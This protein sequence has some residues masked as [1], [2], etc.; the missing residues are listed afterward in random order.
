MTSTRCSPPYA[1]QG[2]TLSTISFY[3]CQEGRLARSNVRKKVN[4]ECH[5][6]GCFLLPTVAQT[7]FCRPCACLLC[8]GA[9]LC[10][11]PC[12]DPLLTFLLLCS[13]RHKIGLGLRYKKF[14]CFGLRYLETGRHIFTRDG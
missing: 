8:L 7:L 9:G 2:L 6:Q 4:A 14:M 1:S 3:T 10:F 12:P 13:F 11:M 5:S